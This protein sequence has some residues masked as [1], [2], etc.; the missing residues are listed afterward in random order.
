MGTI[1]GSRWF[2]R[3]QNVEAVIAA[4]RTVGANPSLILGKYIEWADLQDFDF[5]KKTNFENIV[6]LRVPL[7]NAAYQRLRQRKNSLTGTHLFTLRSESRIAINLG[8]ESILETN[9]ALHPLF[10]FPVLAGSA[11]KGVTRHYVEENKLDLGTDDP[12]IWQIFGHPTKAP[13][14]VT[15]RESDLQEGDV[16]FQDAWPATCNQNQNLGQYLELEI[17]TPHYPNYYQGRQWP[18]DNQ[19]P[20]PIPFLVI[21]KDVIFEFAL[22]LSAKGRAR[23]G[24]TAAAILRQV[25]QWLRL[26]LGTYGL[27]AKTG[28]GYGYFA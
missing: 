13:Q 10:G 18:S 21:K 5:D 12:E 20:T 15:L 3:S 9:I 7:T 25:E 22:A 28:S 6:R 26:A 11:I 27:G 4:A 16:V 17:M 19:D 23:R 2:N 24:A 8:N 14:G 1:P